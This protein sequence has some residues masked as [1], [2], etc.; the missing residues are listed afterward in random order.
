MDKKP[1]DSQEPKALWPQARSVAHLDRST[2]WPFEAISTNMR[3]RI[4][5]DRMIEIIVG[6]E[7]NQTTWYIHRELL[8]KHSPYFRAA[9]QPN[10]FA[11]SQSSSVSLPDDDSDAFEVFT[12]WIYTTDVV[13]QWDTPFNSVEDRGCLNHVK[14]Y[15][16][17]DKLQIPELQTDAVGA[18]ESANSSQ[19][20]ITPECVL[21]TFE[22]SLNGN[23][24]RE[25]L[26]ETVVKSIQDGSIDPNRNM[27][28]DPS[29]DL[30]S[31]SWKE[32]F[33]LGGE[34]VSAVIANI[35]DRNN[36][37]KIA[38]LGLGDPEPQAAGEEA[39]DMEDLFL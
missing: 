23:V 1:L 20:K 21:Y 18:I 3:L 7:P 14:A 10:R 29:N 22:Q 27:M 24:L 5:R 25:M 16:L 2:L 32:L 12:Q 19:M 13:G 31:L 35:V 11:E 34:F 39:S 4:C 8:I 6:T 37:P 36:I 28:H 9:L 33:E 38:S 26:L 15:C 30:N 17:G